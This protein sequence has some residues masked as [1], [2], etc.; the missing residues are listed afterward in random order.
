M[1]GQYFL[2]RLPG[3]EESEQPRNR[4]T[5]S[6]NAG[7]APHDARVRGDSLFGHVGASLVQHALAEF[8]HAARGNTQCGE[9]A[10]S[11]ATPKHCQSSSEA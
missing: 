11:G 3:R 6:A 8:Y 9:V 10:M 1:V 4:K 7:A 5:E 2:F